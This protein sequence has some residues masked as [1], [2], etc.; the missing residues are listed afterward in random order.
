VPTET[1]ALVAE[2]PGL[3]V[4]SAVLVPHTWGLEVTVVL[5]GLREGERYRAVAVDRDGR[6]LPAGE[7]LG[8][9][10]RPAECDLQAALLRQDAS[11]FLLLDSAGGTVASAEL[12]A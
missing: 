7:F 6:Q 3:T 5:T 10:D 4:R 2:Q 8:V 12:P 9:A 1:V 11:A